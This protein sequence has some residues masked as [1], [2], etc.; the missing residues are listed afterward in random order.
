[1]VRSRFSKFLDTYDPHVAMR[2]VKCP[3]L[4]MNGSLDHAV[5]ARENLEE[6]EKTVRA[7]GKPDVTIIELYG[8][9]H[10]FQA[11]K[12]GSPFEIAQIEETIS[13][14]VLQIMA[15]WIRL[16]VGLDK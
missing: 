14:K 1:M 13:P 4:A 3:M 16:H 8:L 5:T 15:G 2:Q 11:A 10:F 9:N 12:T 7:A 6:I